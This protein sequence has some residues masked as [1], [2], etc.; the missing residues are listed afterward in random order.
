MRNPAHV[1]R[2]LLQRV[3]YMVEDDN[4]ERL[5]WSV[6]DQAQDSQPLKLTLL[7]KI[8]AIDIRFM[9][10]NGEWSNFWPPPATGDAGSAASQPDPFPRAVSVKLDLPDVG[11]VERIFLMP[12]A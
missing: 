10:P 6:L 4:L 7:K 8:N 1:A 2:S 11:S 5:S 3:A 9:D 12:E